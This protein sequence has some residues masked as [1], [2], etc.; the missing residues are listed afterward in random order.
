MNTINEINKKYTNYGSSQDG[1][2][3]RTHGKSTHNRT[4]TI[5]TPATSPQKAHFCYYRHKRLDDVS[6]TKK[7]NRNPENTTKISPEKSGKSCPQDT[8]THSTVASPALNIPLLTDPKHFPGSPQRQV[9]FG[10][11]KPV[12]R[13]TY[14]LESLRGRVSQI[15][16]VQQDAV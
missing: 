11:Q 10:Q 13:S 2:L 8:R 12:P 7:K 14:R 16:P 9:S 3:H 5:I 1:W 15:G 4:G 6:N